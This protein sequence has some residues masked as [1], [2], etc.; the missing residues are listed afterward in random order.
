MSQAAHTGR[1]RFSAPTGSKLWGAEVIEAARRAGRSLTHYEADTGQQIWS[2]SRSDGTGPLFLTRR[3][4]IT[5][6]AEVLER[7][8]PHDL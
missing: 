8:D 4:A 6:M 2:W 3:A 7:V 1:P 5:W